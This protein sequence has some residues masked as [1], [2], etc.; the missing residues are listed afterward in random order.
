MRRVDLFK[1]AL[2]VCAA[3]LLGWGIRTD[4]G[5]YRW[6]GIACLAAAVTLRFIRPRTPLN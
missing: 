6:A 4:Q 1:L 3:L 2:S 5:A